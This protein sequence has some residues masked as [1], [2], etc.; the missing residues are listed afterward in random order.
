M[1]KFLTT[2]RFIAKNAG[3]LMVIINIINYSADQIETQ[4]EKIGYKDDEQ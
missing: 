2:V 1:K 3:W 4:A